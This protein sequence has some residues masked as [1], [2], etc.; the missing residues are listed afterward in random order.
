MSNAPSN[1]TNLDQLDEQLVAYLDGELDPQAAR[2][3]ENLLAADEH[4]RRRLNQLASSWDLLDQLPRATVDDLFTRT[5]VEMVALAAEDEVTQAQAADPARRRLRWL[6]GGLAAL[7]AAVVGFVV[8][9]VAMPNQNEAL[10]H[11]LPVV[12]NLELYLNVGS[13]ELLKQFQK[14]HLFMDDAPALSPGKLPDHDAH[15]ASATSGLQ[16]S[17][18]A[19][20]NERRAWVESLGPSDKLELRDEFEKFSAM[21]AK[22]QQALRLFDAQLSS[23]AENLQLRHIMLRYYDWLKTLTSADRYNVVTESSLPEQINLIKQLKQGQL[24]QAFAWLDPGLNLLKDRDSAAV[25]QWMRDFAENHETELTSASPD[26]KRPEGQKSDDRRRRRPLAWLAYQQW[27]SPTAKGT[28][29]VTSTDIHA[30]HP[31]LSSEKQ[32]QLDEEPSLTEQVQLVRQWI[33]TAAAEFR[34]L[35]AQGFG[36]WGGLNPER[37]K[38]FEDQQLSADEKKELEGLSSVDRLRKLIELYQ[39]HRAMDGLRPGS[40]VL[41]QP[42]ESPA[43]DAGKAKDV[44]NTPPKHTE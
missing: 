5:T 18:P 28:P 33:Q 14:E 42:N 11:D 19:S 36:R 29:P 22:Q 1:P 2:Q 37:L 3:M 41:H 27:W 13:V 43:T 40:S 4:A 34:E 23:D 32:K 6:E 8:V 17:I 16:L 26:Q 44:D 35:A 20:P 15:A 24:G 12:K 30:L 39:K 10:L 7:A 21:P 31:L 9:V 25:L 38:R